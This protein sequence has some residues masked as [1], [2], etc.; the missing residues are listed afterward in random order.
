MGWDQLSNL[1]KWYGAEELIRLVHIVV[2]NRH[3]QDLDQTC[4]QLAE[5]IHPLESQSENC[6]QWQGESTGIWLLPE[7][8]RP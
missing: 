3:Q 7:E 1:H 2:I 6:Y 4:Q 8:F 5:K